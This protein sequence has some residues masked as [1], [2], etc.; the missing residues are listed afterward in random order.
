MNELLTIIII[1]EN[2]IHL[3]GSDG[4]NRQKSKITEKLNKSMYNKTINKRKT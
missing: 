1:A 4:F 2:L 3:S